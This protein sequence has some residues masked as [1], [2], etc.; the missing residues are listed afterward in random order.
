MSENKPYRVDDMDFPTYLN[1]PAPRPS[2]TSSIARALMDS[3][4]RRVWHETPRLNPAYSEK[5]KT[6]FDLGTAAHALFVG[7]GAP[8]AMVDAADW[9]S[10]A[11]KEARDAAY[12]DGKTPILAHNM[13]SVVDMAEAAVKQAEATPQTRFCG[14]GG[15]REASVFW[16]H[17]DTWSRCRPDFYDEQN[18]ILVHYKT[19][20]VIMGAHGLPRY[21]A[22]LGWE[23]IAAHYGAGIN[24]LAG[25]EPRQLFAL[26]ENTPPF[27]MVVLELDEAFTL[28]GQMVWARAF[29][30]WRRCLGTG[31]W[32]GRMEGILPLSPPAWHEGAAIAAKDAYEDA[33]VGGDILGKLARW[34]APLIAP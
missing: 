8:L 5:R 25:K 24:A 14:S 7:H 1:D 33:R 30:M 11:A 34:Q 16:K 12:E 21:A 2:L 6:I 3:S 22:S 23:V 19:T 20:S 10:K 17:G 31:N 29:E 15:L 13:D 28:T 27:D 9:R 4:P 32:P 18:N 26:Q